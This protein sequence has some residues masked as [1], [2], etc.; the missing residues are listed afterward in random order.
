MW[1]ID[2]LPWR[3][4]DREQTTYQSPFPDPNVPYQ[5][6]DLQGGQI[7]EITLCMPYHVWNT[8]ERSGILCDLLVELKELHK[9]QNYGGEQVNLLGCQSDLCREI[10]FFFGKPNP[11]AKGIVFQ[12]PY[13]DWL[14]LKASNAW[15]MVLAGLEHSQTE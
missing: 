15:K 7:K 6:R 8:L 4:K 13:H 14:Q 9:E 12:L 10:S 2:W 5:E 1:L 3:R 11:V